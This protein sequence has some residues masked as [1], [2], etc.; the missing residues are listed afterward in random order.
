MRPVLQ[1]FANQ[2]QDLKQSLA[3]VNN[4]RQRAPLQPLNTANIGVISRPS[5]LEKQAQHY[6]QPPHQQQQQQVFYQESQAYNQAPMLMNPRS[7]VCVSLVCLFFF[8]TKN[9]THFSNPWDD[10]ICTFSSH[11]TS[12]CSM[13]LLT[14]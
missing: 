9:N 4:P 13:I 12:Q 7:A 14:Y 2:R 6:F 11:L 5:Q 3:E 1:P 8:V 10:R